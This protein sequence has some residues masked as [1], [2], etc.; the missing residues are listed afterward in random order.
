M[1]HLEDAGSRSASEPGAEKIGRSFFAVWGF[2]ERRLS[3]LILILVLGTWEWLVSSGRVSSLFFPAPSV[4]FKSL[5]VML[6]NGRMMPHLAVSL[7]R[8]LAGFLT[9]G[10]FGML[11]GLVMGWSR[12]LGTVID[13]FIAAMHPVP[14][15]AI[16]PLIMIIFGIGE[17]SKLVVV[18]IAAF[19]PMVINTMAG[20][21]Q[22]NPLYLEVTENYG[23]GPVKVFRR[24]II[25][26]S[27]PLILAGMRLSLNS[28]LV[29]TIA[30]ELVAAD[31]GLG[32][33][34][35]LA[36]ETLRTEELYAGL[37]ITAALGIG[38]NFLL[39]FLTRK[40]VP[41]SAEGAL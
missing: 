41:W 27:L 15:I 35:W 34:I 6:I 1:A 33:L 14:K 25:P 18:A 32:A 37:V 38:I 24:V 40:T 30:V 36:W 11:L 21:R 20:V 29:I 2:V 4:I 39:Q 8:V 28:A 23:A 9:G 5:F 12:R 22:I 3:V 19:F 16:L 17:T 13:P 7:S 31:R 26:G 10:V